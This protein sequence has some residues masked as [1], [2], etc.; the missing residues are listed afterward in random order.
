MS[1]VHLDT[2]LPSYLGSVPALWRTLTPDSLVAGCHKYLPNDKTPTWLNAATL[3][4]RSG[5][6]QWASVTSQTQ[7]P[8]IYHSHRFHQT[9]HRD[10]FAVSHKEVAPSYVT[11]LERDP[12]L[13]K[14]R[15][16]E[17][18]LSPPPTH[19]W[20]GSCC[21]DA[22][23]MSGQDRTG[24]QTIRATTCVFVSPAGTQQ[25][26]RENMPTPHRK[27]PGIWTRHLLVVMQQCH[28][29]RLLRKS[30]SF[31]EKLQHIHF[32]SNC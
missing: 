11:V 25:K 4:H 2:T 26:Q 14:G 23:S 28:Q 15:R 6:V 13:G 7:I 27:V 12:L 22:E 17:L 24:R 18:N 20:A 16:E 1:D 19:S 31:H 29:A 21:A 3:L 8:E 9:L 5:N 30:I 10:D 32:Y